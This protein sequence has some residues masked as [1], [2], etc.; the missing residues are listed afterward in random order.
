M[1]MLIIDGQAVKV[2]EGSTVLDAAKQA[3]IFVPTL[4]HHE[5]LEPFGA[6]RLCVVDVTRPEWEGWWK[7][8]VACMA[9][10]ED[11]WMVSTQTPRVL[12][13][14]K[15]LLDLLLARCPNTPAIQNLAE[16]VGLEKTTVQPDADPTDC[17]LCGL[18]TRVCETYVTAA[19][20]TI[21]RGTQKAIG[22][23]MDRPPQN[24][25]GCGGCALVCPTG[26]I[27]AKEKPL[28]Y[29]IWGQT[30]PKAVCSVNADKCVA[31]GLCEEVCPWSIPRVSFSV[32]R[33]AA[34]FILS[35]QCRGCG[36]CAGACP[37]G[38]I[39]QQGYA[40]DELTEKALVK[41]GKPV[42][43]PI[44]V[45]ACS[46][47][48]LKGQELPDAVQLVEIP[49]AGRISVP[50]VLSLL[51]QEVKGVLI[52][53]RH[54]E[55]CRFNGAEDFI[56]EAVFRMKLGLSM[57]GQPTEW[58][59]FVVPR[60]GPDGPKTAVIEYCRNIF[61]IPAGSQFAPFAKQVIRGETTA[62]SVALIQEM[63]LKPKIPSPNLAWLCA[64]QLL[65]PAPN[66]DVLF[67]G[68]LPYVDILAGMLLRPVNIP[69]VIQTALNVL[70]HTGLDEPGVA[71][72]DPKHLIQEEIDRFAKARTVFVLCEQ[73]KSMLEAKGILAVNLVDWLPKHICITP[74][75]EPVKVACD[76]T[77]ISKTLVQALGFEP[78]VLGPEPLQGLF[79]SPKQ[80]TMALERFVTAEQQGA[81]LV[82]ILDT[83]AWTHAAV[84][85]RF[86]TWRPS[87]VIPVLPHEL[88]FLALGQATFSFASIE[89][90]L[91]HTNKA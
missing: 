52:L 9:K 46:R 45:F 68:T 8:V 43:G 30:F 16:S 7:M 44:V 48:N 60:A 33:H 28:A 47:C 58:V 80:G 77:D 78:L 14:R 66:E 91:E 17:V 15:T 31:C 10:C 63:S 64:H 62:T 87:R 71:F 54:Q 40:F 25:V 59:E 35:E 23:F 42:H 26:N 88:A 36:V 55:T 84:L 37:T 21:G 89:H 5:G 85:T 4:C 70:K 72:A 2:K 53:G 12:E 29:E 82:L 22:T 57:V 11:G 41:D 13:T 86:G 90:A 19:I 6:C 50:L 79:V 56:Q 20:S 39:I 83:M 81:R 74:P 73:D 61:D 24:C 49:C 51:G 34:A 3:G 67:V 38:A 18:C 1:P 32:D 65:P 69:K 76:D 27:K 75:T